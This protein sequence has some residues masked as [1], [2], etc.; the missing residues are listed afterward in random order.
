MENW[1]NHTRKMAEADTAEFI[2]PRAVIGYD[3]TDSGII[4]ETSCS[5]FG[6]K[7]QKSFGYAFPRFTDM[8]R[9]GNYKIGI[10]TVG[11]FAFR[12]RYSKSG[13]FAN[14]TLMAPNV[15]AGEEAVISDSGDCISMALSDAE[16]KIRK[17][18]FHVSL[19]SSSGK[20]LL[21]LP[22]IDTS[23]PNASGAG[24]FASLK[25]F[26]PFGLGEGYTTFTSKMK[27]N[28]RIYGLGEKF[29]GIDRRGQYLESIQQ[30]CA[31][32]EGARTYKNIPF[33]MS[34][35][36]YGLYVNS[37]YLMDF[38][39]G[40]NNFDYANIF[41]E[42]DL[43][44]IFLISGPSMKDILYRYCLITGFAPELPGW[45]YGLWMSRNSYENEDIVKKIAA[46]LRKHDIPCDVLHL[47]TFWFEK[48]WVCD[49]EFSKERFPKPESLMSDLA[50]MGFTT[51]I[52]QMPYVHESL[53][54]F[55][56]GMNNGYFVKKE[57]G[58]VYMF[59]WFGEQYGLIDFS[60]VDAVKWYMDKI[61]SVLEMGAKVVK[62]DI[63][64]G[65]PVDG[66]YKNI[67]GKE[68]HNLFPLIY[69]KAMYE[70]AEDVHGKGIVWARSSYAGGQRYPLPWSGDSRSTFENLAG[71]LRSGLSI[72]L[73]GHPYWSHDIGGFIGIPD[74]ELYV[75]WAQIGLF[76]SHAR[77]HGGGNNNPREP[78]AF[79]DEALAIFRKYAK[80]RY[81]LLPY[82]YSTE[83][84][85]VE[86]GMPFMRHMALMHQDDRNTHGIYD[87][88]Y[89]GDSIMVAPLLN[90][91][92]KRQAYI[93]KGKWYDYHTGKALS[94]T[95]WIDIEAGLD[96][97]PMY[98]PAGAV[99]VYGPGKSHTGE[100]VENHIDIHVYSGGESSFRYKSGDDDFIFMVKYENG[101]CLFN[102]GGC[103]VPYKLTVIGE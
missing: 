100:E 25:D 60:N 6:T 32:N 68:M 48:D 67:S 92:G 71:A 5:K 90:Y 83:A 85:S 98:I 23:H 103:T 41:L 36:G 50:D 26:F 45:S 7:I 15:P 44:D 24:G 55:K 27:L 49:L 20:P 65:M 56:E 80:L 79:G 95:G 21:E 35:E 57:T 33:Y 29:A 59:D 87:Q 4:L 70:A 39:I 14:D 84:C 34:T 28:E 52:W 13:N 97:L 58:G 42:N 17:N 19:I 2:F 37:A 81:S 12:I 61:K 3:R 86:T 77:C 31:G 46:D 62:T 43:M 89:F 47:D 69:N 18:P 99:I 88:Y 75:R 96:T 54:N 82:I 101:R 1:I 76:S 78:W 63:A 102:D 74:A 40:S 10:D 73:S 16:I 94:E 91:G 9:A 30:D 38:D 53:K 72:G 11:S 93:P 22:G 66:I 8:G 64:E 51:S